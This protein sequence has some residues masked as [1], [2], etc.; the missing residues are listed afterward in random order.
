MNDN[1]INNDNGQR[2]VE[3]LVM[4]PVQPLIDT[5]SGDVRFKENKIVTYLLDNGGIDLNQIA[6]LDFSR[7]DREQ[8]AQLIGYSYSGASDLSY[9]SDEVLSVAESV[10]LSKNKIDQKDAMIA[11]LKSKLDVLRENLADAL[12]DLFEKNPDDLKGA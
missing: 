4:H 8:F 10:Y 6:Q 12:C 11:E 9:M 2:H 5:E 7:E 3:T 1:K